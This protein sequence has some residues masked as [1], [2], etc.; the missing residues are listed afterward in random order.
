MVLTVSC[1]LSPA[2]G[3]SCHRRPREA[4]LLRNLTPASG[5]QDHTPSPSASAPFVRSAS[6]STASCPAS[7]TIS[8]RPSVGQ[9]GKSYSLICISEKQ[10]YFCN[11]AGQVFA[12]RAN[13]LSETI[14]LMSSLRKQ[15]THTPRPLFLALRPDGFLTT[16]IGGYGSPLSQ[17]RHQPTKHTGRRPPSRSSA[18][19]PAEHACATATHSNSDRVQACRIFL[20]SRRQSSSGYR[21]R[22]A[23]C[24]QRTP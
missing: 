22:S 23:S 2:T 19:T 11:G 3:L 14:F 20:P 13:H 6:A 7:V 24:R 8:S 4:L 1:A 16:Y 5:R 15:G 17:G 21:R 18:E 10:K 12:R 9:D